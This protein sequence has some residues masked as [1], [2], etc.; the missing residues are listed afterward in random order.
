MNVADNDPDQRV[1]TGFVME[2]RPESFQLSFERAPVWLLALEPSMCSAVY[3]K[4][5]GIATPRFAESLEQKR[6]QP[7]FVQ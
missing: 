2:V 4:D 6:P 1:E 7:D 3:F 5:V